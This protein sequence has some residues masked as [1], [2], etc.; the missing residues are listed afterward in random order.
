MTTSQ[1]LGDELPPLTSKAFK[2]AVLGVLGASTSEKWTRNTIADSVMIPLIGELGKMPHS[3]LIPSE[4]DTGILIQV[5]AEKQGV[6]CQAIDADWKRLGRRARA[7]RDSR[8]LKESTHLLLF[9]GARSDYYEK[10]AIREAKKG[11]RVFTID[12]NSMEM[13]EWVVD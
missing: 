4:G 6:A 10:V 11:K 3:L 8:I 5:W 7:L 2:P 12:S 1:I 9:L 13:V